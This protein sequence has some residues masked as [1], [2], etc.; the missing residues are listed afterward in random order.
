M[1]RLRIAVVVLALF[2][3]ASPARAQLRAFA[4]A[5]GLNRKLSGH[6]ED[7]TRT[8]T[9]D[10]R[11]DSAILGRKRD[12][13]VYL[14]P[15]YDP[16]KSYPL[17]LYFH[18]S[19]VD[20][21]DFVGSR[22]LL[23]LDRM[24]ADG[25]FPP[26]IVACP[27]GTTTGK[28]HVLA[29]NSF[30]LNGEGGRFED[31]ILQEVIPFITSHFAIRPERE[32][33]AILGVSGGGLGAL[34]IAI[35]HREYFGA[36]AALA[37][38]ANLMYTNDQ[39]DALADFDP[40]TY[41]WREHYDPNEVLGTFYHGLRKVRARHYATPVFGKDQEQVYARIAAINPANLIASTDLKPGELAIYLNYA[42]QDG[43]NFDAQNQSF[44]WLAAQRGIRV[45]LGSIP[46]ANHNLRYFRHAH[47][48]AFEWLATQIPR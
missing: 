32:A 28:N 13:Y 27:D 39:N 43:Y 29:P 41:R 7:F 10:N 5:Q 17:L 4:T 38:P 36:V 24:I 14:P 2:A 31:H 1:L 42:G 33:H 18:I 26:A 20:E 8:F 30:Y 19:R 11:I 45:D 6:V 46:E 40:A 16:R 22:R 15:G 23:E 9:H 37:A 21:R 48:P 25:K 34:S 12:L 35:R 44:A 47:E 3:T